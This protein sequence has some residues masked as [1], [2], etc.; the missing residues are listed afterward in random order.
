MQGELK[1]LLANLDGVSVIARGDAL[2]AFDVHCPLGSLPLACKTE[3][4][5]VPAAIPYLHPDEQRLAK[6]RQ[7]LAALPG[8][9]SRSPVAGNRDHINDRN[10]SIALSRLAPLLSTPDVRFISVQRDLREADREALGNAALTYLGDELA[11]FADTAAVLALADLVI[12]VD[13]SVAHLAGALGRPLWILLPFWPDWRW[14]SMAR[15]P[16]VSGPRGC[17]A[18]AR[19]GDWDRRNRAGARGNREIRELA[20]AA[21]S[22]SASSRRRNA[23]GRSANSRP[24]MRCAAF[25]CWPGAA[26]ISGA[27]ARATARAAGAAP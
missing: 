11:D 7:R 5:S 19:T 26:T 23:F 4:A 9:A 18:R 21:C 27:G 20:L 8:D 1:P 25:A 6:W 24:A 13:T 17:S 10:R 12:T 22:H 15:K 3:P 14:T 2:P 16:L